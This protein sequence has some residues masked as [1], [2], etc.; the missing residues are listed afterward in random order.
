MMSS[1]HMMFGLNNHYQTFV[2]LR[3]VLKLQWCTAVSSDGFLELNS[4]SNRHP[5]VDGIAELIKDFH[6]VLV[7]PYPE[8]RLLKHTHKECPR[9]SIVEVEHH[10][11]WTCIL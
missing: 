2:M 5:V 9:V 7:D 4:T 11:N 10:R 1:H 6:S 3:L 8:T